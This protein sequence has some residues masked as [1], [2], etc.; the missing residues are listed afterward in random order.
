MYIFLDTETTGL[1]PERHEVIEVAL[2]TTDNQFN[3]TGS[4]VYK[5]KPFNIS[6]A[7][8]E[9]LKVNGYSDAAWADAIEPYEA[10]QAIRS[11]MDEYRRHILVAHNPSFDIAHIQ[12][13]FERN[14]EDPRIPNP[15]MDTRGVA[16]QTFKAFGLGGTSMNKICFFLQWHKPQH[17]AYN[18]ALLCIR[19]M[20]ASQRSYLNN[21]I[22]LLFT[23]LCDILGIDN[24][25]V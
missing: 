11:I 12:T 20:K 24:S 6:R 16:L 18:D 22:R 2:I 13:L 25:F 3:I 21:A 10:A 4:H 7:D 9:A 19:I 15:I 17:R 5:I 1:S 8:P 23:R 14:K